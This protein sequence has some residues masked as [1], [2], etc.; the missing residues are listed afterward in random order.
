[1]K[2]MKDCEVETVL[3]S[4]SE[5]RDE[6]DRTELE[7]RLQRRQRQ[8]DQRTVRTTL[9][10]SRVGKDPRPIIDNPHSTFH[11]P[12]VSILKFEIEEVVV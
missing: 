6:R 11:I 2:L 4:T 1:M 5:I 10:L 3:N 8:R 7:L 12:K 9:S